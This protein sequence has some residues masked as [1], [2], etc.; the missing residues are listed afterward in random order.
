MRIVKLVVAVIATLMVAAAHPAAAQYPGTTSTTLAPTSQ[1]LGT[2]AVGSETTAVSCQRGWNTSIPG[3][4]PAF[5]G[6]SS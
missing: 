3:S 4:S 1:N 2:L 5:G 6:A